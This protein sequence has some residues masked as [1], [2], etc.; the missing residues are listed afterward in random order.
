MAKKRQSKKA[1]REAKK[2]AKK[3]PKLFITLVVLLAI[4][5]IIFIVLWRV[6]VISFGNKKTDKPVGTTTNPVE[7]TTTTITPTT[8][9]V[10]EE[11]SYSFDSNLKYYK[12]EYDSINN[13]FLVK[14]EASLEKD[15]LYII[16]KDVSGVVSLYI[17]ED[18]NTKEVSIGV[19]PAKVEKEYA[20]IFK[21]TK[22]SKNEFVKY[23]GGTDEGVCYDEFQI[24]FMM[25]GNDKAGDCTYIKAGDTDIL[26][27]A[28]STSGSYTTTSAYTNQYCKD[29][30][31]EYVIATH[32]DQDHIAA[33]PNFFNNYEVDTVIDFS[34]ETYTKYQAFKES[35][36]T[37]RDY[38]AGTTK[39]TATYGSYLEARDTYAK[40]HYTAGDCYNNINGAKSTYQLS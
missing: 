31:F 36:K 8:T 2:L 15:S 29:N 3:S 11:K 30:S 9:E 28:G 14:E 12:V 37:T 35:K 17:L 38:F 1:I 18:K 13:E 39:T 10:I 21:E 16:A 6:G 20:W 24:H 27:D 34:C 32:G 25:L 5:S 40:K 23:V 33:F 7:T 22:D 19:L 26:I 4:A